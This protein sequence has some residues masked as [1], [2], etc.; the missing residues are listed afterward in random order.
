MTSRER[1][2]ATLR[3]EKPDRI[4]RAESPWGETWA[5]WHDQG[6]PRDVDMIDYFK[7]DFAG[8]HGPDLSCACPRGFRRTDTY[9]PAT[10]ANGV[11]A[12]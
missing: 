4:G 8:I 6:L 7:W 1:I 5:V 3:G 10:D 12:D 11:G 2:L 9:I